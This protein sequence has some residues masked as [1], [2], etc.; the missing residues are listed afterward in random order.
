MIIETIRNSAQ[1]VGVSPRVA[2]TIAMLESSLNP[3]AQA[4]TSSAGGLFQFVDS[5]WKAMVQRYGNEYGMSI[6]DKMNP[7]AN[8]IM[9][10]LLIKE[11]TKSLQRTLSYAPGIREIYLAHFAGI[12]KAIKVLRAL[13]DKPKQP[14]DSIFS[15]REINAN[16]Y[17]LVGT[18]QTAYDN[19]TNKAART[20]EE[21]NQE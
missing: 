18:V 16:P 1:L 12:G 6:E 2:L 4:S 10:C 17:I 13:N 11:N 7:S 20:Y 3:D 5:T 9:G 15:Y 8:S 21:F 14:V 19:L